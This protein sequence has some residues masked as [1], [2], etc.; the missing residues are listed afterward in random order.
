MLI[1]PDNP[2]LS[3]RLGSKLRH[4]HIQ[5]GNDVF[6]ECDIRAN[7]WVNDIGWRFEGRPCDFNLW[8]A[9]PHSIPSSPV[10]FADTP[11]GCHDSLRIRGT[12]F[13]MTS[14]RGIVQVFLFPRGPPM[15]LCFNSSFST[16][17]ALSIVTIY[18][19]HHLPF[20][21]R[22]THNHAQT[23]VSAAA[24]YCRGCYSFIYVVFQ[25]TS[26]QRPV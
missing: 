5:E 13:H 12:N 11:S 17:I 7:P 1:F 9:A 16:V 4:Q 10:F 22:Y 6:F 23:R 3:L 25:S 20:P 24:A 8:V 18:P 2:I 21:V 15:L 19:N 14:P 26:H